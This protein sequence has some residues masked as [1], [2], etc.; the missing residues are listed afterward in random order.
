LYAQVK[1]PR[2]QRRNRRNPAPAI[3]VGVVLLIFFCW[4][5]NLTCAK[6]QTVNPASLGAYINEVRPAIEASSLVGQDW[7]S[8]KASLPTEIG[9]AQTLDARLTELVDRSKDAYEKAVAIQPP[10]EMRRCGESLIIC[11]D[12]RYRGMESYRGNLLYFTTSL[13]LDAFV[14]S[15]SEDTRDFFYA[16][17]AYEYFRA[18]AGEVLRE[19]GITDISIPESRWVENADEMDSDVIGS[20]LQ[21]ARS[22]ELH[23]VSVGQLILDPAKVS[24]EKVGGD[25]VLVLPARDELSVTVTIENQGNRRE[26]QVLVSVALYPVSAPSEQQR[27]E[28]TIE[29]LESGGKVDVTFRGLNPAVNGARNILEIKVNAVPGEANMDNNSKLVYFVM[30]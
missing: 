15:I 27:M 28:S 5:F 23:G 21:I 3:I 4:V 26:T 9:D 11:L 20:S 12:Q 19:K 8:L 1:A 6:K 14:A 17:G 29:K 2:F 18:R 24:E 25:I 22:N 16:D 13:N 30:R 10:D 7:R